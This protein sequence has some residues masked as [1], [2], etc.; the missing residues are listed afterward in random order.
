MPPTFTAVLGTNTQRDLV[1]A[2]CNTV[3]ESKQGGVYVIGGRRHW[4]VKTEEGNKTITVGGEQNHH[5]TAENG[6]GSIVDQKPLNAVAGMG[7][8]S[9]GFPSGKKNAKK[10]S[11][12]QCHMRKNICK[13]KTVQHKTN[14]AKLLL[15]K[16]EF[17]SVDP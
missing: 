9:C 16:K 1:R 2:R 17:S 8:E 15:S 3:N 11:S 14:Q 5:S 12:T 6:H 10:H 7:C 4:D 13:K